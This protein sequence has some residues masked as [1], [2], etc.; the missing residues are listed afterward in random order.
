MAGVNKKGSI[1]SNVFEVADIIESNPGMIVGGKR[2]AREGSLGRR[3]KVFAKR[4]E[5]RKLMNV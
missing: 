3:E 1:Y 5:R 4:P 2:R